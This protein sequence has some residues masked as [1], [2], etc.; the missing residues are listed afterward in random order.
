M[1]EPEKFRII[2]ANDM[3]VLMTQYLDAAQQ[4]H[5]AMCCFDDDHKAQSALNSA[6]HS[7]LIGA[8][9]C[10]RLNSEKPRVESIEAKD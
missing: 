3:H 5:I 2:S 1:G 7:V 10:R 4:I 9:E 8:G 6:M